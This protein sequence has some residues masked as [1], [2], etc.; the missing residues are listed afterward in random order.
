MFDN[1]IL[2]AYGLY[3]RHADRVS[4]ENT[5]FTLYP[6]HG[7]TRPAVLRDDAP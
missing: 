7:D 4:L 3:I 6:G 2:P 5:T 1:R